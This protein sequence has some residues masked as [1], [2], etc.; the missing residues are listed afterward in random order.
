MKKMSPMNIIFNSMFLLAALIFSS[1]AK[2]G[3]NVRAVK[4]T[5]GN[6]MNVATS[7]TSI[8]AA[9]AQSLMYDINS[10]SWP[11]PSETSAEV[12]IDSEIKTPTNKF[13]AIST[14]H[15]SEGVDSRGVTDDT[16]NATKLDIRARCVGENCEKYLM[17]ATIVKGGYAIHQLAVISYSNDC[18]YNLE[19]VNYTV[20]S[21][22]Q[23]LDQLAQQNNIQ[24]RN[25]RET[26]CPE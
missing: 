13:I 20:K 16:E 19:N 11:I 2:K 6:V 23:N 25:D 24:P 26:N 3:T 17:L 22:Y 18:K 15:K 14:N 9:S 8:A 4:Q 7:T 12:H 10:I 21:F 5:E 1:C